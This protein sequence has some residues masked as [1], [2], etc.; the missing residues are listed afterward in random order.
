MQTDTSP[1]AERYFNHFP[2]TRTY[3]Q[4]LGFRFYRFTPSRFHWNGGFATARWFDTSRI[5]R[6]NP[7]NPEVEQQI[8][9]HMN[10]DHPDTLKH[11]VNRF[12][13]LLTDS[14]IAMVGIDGEG[15]DLRVDDGLIRIALPRRISNVEAAREVLVELAAQGG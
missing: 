6:D 12:T 15:V 14:A 1:D 13:H 3:Y 4:E 8:L 5:L 10:L 7:F 2:Q 9:D 11:Y